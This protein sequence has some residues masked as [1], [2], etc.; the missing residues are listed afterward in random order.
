[1]QSTF[2]GVEIARRGILAHA[3]QLRTTGHNLS[4]I[5]T[6]GYSRQRVTLASEVPRYMPGATRAELAGQIGQGVNIQSIRRQKDLQIEEQIIAQS[7]KQ[8]FWDTRSKYIGRLEDIQNEVDNNSSLRGAFDRYWS[9]WEELS[10]YPQEMSV[11]LQLV[12]RTQTLTAMI[13]ER[14]QQL[15]AVQDAL[16]VEIDFTV[17]KINEL[18]KEIATLNS[19]I[20]QARS[21]QI[22]PNDLLDRR[23]MF[24]QELGGLVNITT[25]NKD[26]DEFMVHTNGKILVQG[27]KARSF[28]FSENATGIGTGVE[29]QVYWQDSGD[30]VD[31]SGGKLSALL[32]LRDDDVRQ[33]IQTLNTFSISLIHNTNEIHRQGISLT[34][35][36]GLNF[37]T[38][39]P[40]V[41]NALGNYDVDLDGTFDQSRIYS[42][43][44]TNTLAL[45]QQIGFSGTLT[46]SG[47]EGDSTIQI[48]YNGTDTVEDIIT[49]INTSGAEVVASL[50]TQG[51]LS[52]EATAA[53]DKAN[54]DF[55]IRYLE[56]SGQFLVGYSGMLLQS[57][58]A[59]SFNWQ[60]ANAVD[61]L[62]SLDN[63]SVAPFLNPA[64]SLELNPAIAND[65]RRVATAYPNINDQLDSGNNSAA[66]DIAA[67]R[68]KQLGLSNVESY[69]NF[70][71][72]SI[73]LIGAKG[74]EAEVL[75]K[76]QARI[77]QDLQA[78][79]SEVSGV[80]LDEELQNLVKF[81]TAYQGVAKFLSNLD[82][83]YEA[84]L[85]I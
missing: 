8:G 78:R 25:S 64:S 56:D 66:L 44:G 34:N 54:V 27:K 41:L 23:D 83:I 19:S 5:N 77:L 85:A 31:R 62:Q 60:T 46:V 61:A 28:S 37:F 50:N 81:Q 58:A 76:T 21:L 16:H 10:L 7:H 68:T 36:T 4:N 30:L 80:D 75:S 67:L 72:H 26:S 32:Q 79:Q 2:S 6:P 1:M 38:E 29:Y 20:Q 40:T 71:S 3:Q 84:L 69:D 42:V 52:F 24:L 9:S 33:E 43:A 14:S 82:R 35:E 22:E 15:D 70:F 51:Q 49:R 17:S 55:V 11:R 74:Q 53:N 45:N 18:A 48:P 12:E 39:R 59:G 65:V 73:A 63:V 57:G 47:R 13:R